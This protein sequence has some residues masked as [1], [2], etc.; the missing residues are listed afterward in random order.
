MKRVFNL[1]LMLFVAPAFAAEGMW[2]PAQLPDLANVLE[3]RGLQIDPRSMTDLTGHPM[4]AIVSLGGCSASFVSPQGLVIT[5]HHCA[6]GSIS[7]NSTEERNLLRDGFVAG[8]QA[9]ELPARPGSRVLVTVK[10][11]GR[12]RHHPG[13]P[14]CRTGRPGPLPGH[15][16][17]REGTG[18]GMR[19]GCRPPLPHRVLPR[20]L[21]L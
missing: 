17:W 2:T 3:S 8:S 13:R 6:Y 16:G 18:A 19:R 21:T 11:E 9:E 5:N 20:W 7:Y 4:K 14:A 10:V 1:C 15:R 12:D